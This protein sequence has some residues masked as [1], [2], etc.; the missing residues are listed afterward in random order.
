MHLFYYKQLSQY[1]KSIY[2]KLENAVSSLQDE[3]VL[4][5]CIIP[6]DRLLEISR[7]VTIDHPEYYWTKGD[8]DS[9]YEGYNLRIRFSYLFSTSD[10]KSIDI[11]IINKINQIDIHSFYSD[12]KIVTNITKWMIDNIIYEPDSKKLY[13]DS[14]QTIYSPLIDNRGVCMGIAKT[15]YLL[16]SLAGLD[17]II[18]LGTVFGDYKSGHSWNIVNIKGQYYHVD[19]TMQYKC[20]DELWKK[21]YGTVDRHC[22]LVPFKEIQ[23]SHTINPKYKY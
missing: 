14:N 16:S 10:I 1:E 17:S 18:V 9:K 2:W 15:F 7:M 8:F 19:V 5:N 13:D 6:I 20:F 21:T 12:E 22:I 23:K 3:I 4:I 11:N